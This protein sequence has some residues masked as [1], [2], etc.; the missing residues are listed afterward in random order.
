MKKQTLL[1]LEA[2]GD[3]L[4]ITLAS[5]N[6][7]RDTALL[8]SRNLIRHCANTIRAIHRQEMD[9]AQELLKK[10]EE[11]SAE[12]RAAVA[13]DPDLYFAGYTQDG[14]KEWVEANLLLA[15]VTEAQLPTPETLH[16]EA[17]TYLK[18]LAE[19]ATELRRTVLDIIRDDHSEQA[20]RL[21]EAMDEIYGLLV[22]IDFPDA[23]TGGLRRST[24]VVRGVR[25]RT[26]GDLTISIR[27][28]R[29]QQALQRART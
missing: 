4:R 17:S 14:L 20:E 19:A 23:I 16:V 11:T 8:H 12:L 6:E 18:G 1:A 24:D 13:D 15:L 5:K 26:R 22:T 27:Q 25:E 2:I 3:R 28:Q 10:A 7:A 21:L 9:V 29:L